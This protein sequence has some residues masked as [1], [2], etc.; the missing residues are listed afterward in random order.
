MAN[1]TKDDDTPPGARTFR[2]GLAWVFIL[3]FVAIVIVTIALMLGIT[4]HA[5]YSPSQVDI[6]PYNTV[7]L[8]MFGMGLACLVPAGLLSAKDFGQMVPIL[9][10]YV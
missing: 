10:K 7:Y 4:L 5:A 8:L 9:G 3:L 2:G 6:K 1:S